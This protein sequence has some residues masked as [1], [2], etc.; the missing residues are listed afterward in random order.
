[1]LLLFR[2]I[3]V[4]PEIQINSFKID[5]FTLHLRIIR[6]YFYFQGF[7]KVLIF[8]IQ[9]FLF[10]SFF[11]AKSNS[12]P[13]VVMHTYNPSYSGGEGK[14]I[15]S[16]RPAREKLAKLSKTKTKGKGKWLK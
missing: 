3:L 16:L 4:I 2:I 8:G 5:I 10:F 13:G 6:K 11:S 7:K 14:K 1:L 15:V 12:E 9:Y